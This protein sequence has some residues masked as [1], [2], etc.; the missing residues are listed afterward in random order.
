MLNDNYPF[1]KACFNQPVEY[2]PVWIM[3]QAGRYLKE[4][5]QVREK[6]TFLEL[7]KTP[8]LAAEVTIQPVDIL[9]V[10]A[11]IL[12]SDILIPLEPMGIK[13][14][15]NEGPVLEN[16][17]K[18]TEDVKKLTV[19]DPVASVGF[20]METIRILR[21][22]LNGRV[23]L[24]GFAGAPFT[25]ASYM[26]EGGS[27][28]S[29][30]KVKSFMFSQPA[31]WHSLMEKVADTVI[32][33]LNAQI[34]AGAQAVQLFDSWGGVLS[35][36][37][38][39]KYVLP[40]SKK[41]IANLNRK[42]VPVIHFVQGNPALLPLVAQAGSDVVGVDWRINIDEARRLVRPGQALQG[43]LDPCALFL[44]PQELKLRIKD[45]VD[46][47]GKQGH[48]FNLGHGI[49][50]STPVEKAKLLVETV[51]QLTQTNGQ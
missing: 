6:V 2:T 30:L 34:A 44:P 32:L 31:A 33:Y 5:R 48:I 13:L 49:L 20:V 25:L 40:Y 51:H 18:T 11:A 46:R 38:Y 27:S 19:P 16:P 15:F 23:P 17:V 45:V 28:S 3:R 47:A 14:H 10:D 7:C 21:R 29:F 8:E 4:Y 9:G 39:E 35:P 12:F 37:D 36:Y 43:N 50:P 22:E 24:I 41:V 42:D 26:I 1:I